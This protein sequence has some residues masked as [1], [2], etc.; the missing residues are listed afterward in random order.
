ML[1]RIRDLASDTVIYGLSGVISRFIGL[2]LVPIFTRIFSPADYGVLNLVSTTLA[3]V[4]MLAVLGLDAAADRWYWDT[5][6]HSA[7]KTAI[8]TWFW[9]QLGLSALFCSI[10]I[11]SSKYLAILVIGSADAQIYFQIAS[12]ALL[13]NVGTTVATSWFRM[14]RLP[15][16]AVGYALTTSLTNIGLSVLLVVVLKKGLTGAFMAQLISATLMTAVAVFL[17][18][19]WINP[20]YFR[21]NRLT[22]ML[23]YGLPFVPAGLGIWVINFSD[24][25]FLK[26]FQTITE[27]GLYSVAI[28]V[29]SLMALGTNAFKQSWSPFALS[30]HKEKDANLVYAK[31]LLVYTWFGCLVS[32]GLSL[33]AYDAIRIIATERYLPAATPVGYLSMGFIFSGMAFIAGLG[34]ALVKKTTAI[35]VSVTAS[36]GFN[37]LM[38]F[39]LIPP[40][41][42]DGAAISTMLTW[43]F[44]VA[45]LFYFSQRLYPIPYGFKWALL[46]VAVSIML[47]VA[48]QFWHVESFLPRVLRNSVLVAVF[49]P[50]LLVSGTVSFS[51]MRRAAR[52]GLRAVGILA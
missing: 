49:L 27:I 41:G 1:T 36:A 23:R 52:R 26:H 10:L 28:S 6:D 35:G 24:R 48:G 37:V 47:M 18:K 34:P 4:G 20:F 43:A 42:K 39:L 3:I 22:K 5:D 17:L 32:L 33:F 31:V 30:I 21:T 8:S 11:C 50:S 7:R 51:D 25:F 2:F 46:F 45:I 44:Y 40:L 15:C 13:F 29:A 9:T 12:T 19:D 16:Y 14:Q 38:N